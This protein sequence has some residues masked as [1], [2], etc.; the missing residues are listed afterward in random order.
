MRFA[1]HALHDAGVPDRE[2]HVSM[3]RNMKCALG[4]CGRCQFG[5]MLSAGTAPWSATIAL[6]T[7]SR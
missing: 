6:L 7:C 1:A 2:V 5:P 3:E 4:H